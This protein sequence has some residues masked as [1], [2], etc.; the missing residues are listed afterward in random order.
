MSNSTK[1]SFLNI[2]FWLILF[3]SI[4]FFCAM[5]FFKFNPSG[6]I[7][8]S[9]IACCCI[10]GVLTFI[11]S[12]NRVNFWFAVGLL[13]TLLSDTFLV[14]LQSQQTLAMF[15]FSVTQ[16]SY[17]MVLYNINK[18]KTQLILNLTLRA[19]LFIA[20]CS[21][22]WIILGSAFSLLVLISLF[23]FSNLL[24]NL[25]FS[26]VNIKKCPLLFCGLLLF[27]MCDILIGLQV[28]TSI[29]NVPA[30]ANILSVLNSH[31][32]LA[33]VFYI[34]SQLLITLSAIKNARRCIIQKWL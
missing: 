4:G 19:G 9:S 28:L 1:L 15:L 23:Y 34:P 29:I 7:A 10:V 26:G 2:L 25:I 33:W 18:N 5:H 11:L 12:K 21:V 6:S 16:I 17:F 3:F 13:F 32:D 27:L 30:I 8:Y 14:L 20:L 31:F 24:F 22:A